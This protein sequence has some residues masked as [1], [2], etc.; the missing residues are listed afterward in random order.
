[1]GK[2]PQGDQEYPKYL[3]KFDVVV[4]NAAE[5]S[6]LKS[7]RAEVVVVAVSQQGEV[8]AVKFK[9]QRGV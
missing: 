9:K 3:A 2:G 4:K 8:R 7:G 6:A 5:E 1:M